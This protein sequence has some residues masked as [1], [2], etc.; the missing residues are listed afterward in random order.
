MSR[1]F[2]PY[3]VGLVSAVSASALGVAVNVATDLQGNLLAW[4]TVGTITALTGTVGG[5]IEG[6][7][8]LAEERESGDP[9]ADII[10]SIECEVRA[11]G[12]G[13]MNVKV[14]DPEAERLLPHLPALV[15]SLGASR[16]PN[17][18]LPRPLAVALVTRSRTTGIARR[19]REVDALCSGLGGLD[20]R[21]CVADSAER[22]R[23]ALRAAQVVLLDDHCVEAGTRPLVGGLDLAGLRGG[24]G[25]GLAARVIVLGCQDGAAAAHTGALRRSLDRPVAFLGCDGPVPTGHAAVLYPH[26][27]SQLDGLAGGRAGES[28][29]QAA[30]EAAIGLA[31]RQEAQLDW[32]RWSTTVLHPAG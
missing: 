19:L 11:D 22:R 16:A 13:S 15:P 6:N 5:V 21:L 24:G 30:L 1:R 12:S 26:V 25:D 29:L 3:L 4:V 18:V 27:L 31:K 7:R 17:G 32:G 9:L 20:V 2:R 23:E 8:E 10:L 28:E 14:H